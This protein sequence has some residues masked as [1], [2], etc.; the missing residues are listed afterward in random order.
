LEP[1][2]PPV[3]A[4]APAPATRMAI[5]APESSSQSSS[6]G[7]FFSSLAR[8]VGLGGSDNTA[9]TAPIAA[10]PPASTKPKVET[11][12]R[13]DPRA[14]R[15]ASRTSAPKHVA[16]KA[17]AK[18]TAKSDATRKQANAISGAQPAVP[19]NGFDSR[20]SAMR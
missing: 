16:P 15:T 14:A 8:K 2:Q 12:K 10:R 4:E 11:A 6:S 13:H 20:F 17:S 1:E 3:V 9:S 19:S 7:N 5:A 18:T